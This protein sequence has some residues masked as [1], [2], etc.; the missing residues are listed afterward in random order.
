MYKLHLHWSFLISFFLN[1]RR[2]KIVNFSR[3]FQLLYNTVM[4][5]RKSNHPTNASNDPKRS[6][7]SP[8]YLRCSWWTR[9]T[10]CPLVSR[11][12]ST[13]S[14]HVTDVPYLYRRQA[15]LRPL[16][17]AVD[18]RSWHNSFCR[19]VFSWIIGWTTRIERRSLAQCIA[20][21]RLKDDVAGNKFK[22]KTSCGN[23]FFRF[24]RLPKLRSLSHS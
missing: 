9:G 18:A 8:L 13:V 1:I 24:M 4:Y 16:R 23:L 19:D 17:W 2:H 22:K 3:A 20:L 6:C 14:G 15:V 5:H 21:F 11:T 12:R 10:C 7:W